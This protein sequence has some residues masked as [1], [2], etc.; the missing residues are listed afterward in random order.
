MGVA[1]QG[2]AVQEA[3]SSPQQGLELLDDEAVHSAAP[4]ELEMQQEEQQQ[5]L[6]AEK[7]QQEELEEQQRL[8]EEQ[9]R[10]LA[11]QEQEQLRVEQEE[12]EQQQRQI[13]EQRVKREAEEEGLQRQQRQLEAEERQQRLALEQ[14]EEEERLAALEQEQQAREEEEQ[15]A[16]QL[17]EEEAQAQ[18]SKEVSSPLSSVGGADDDDNPFGVSGMATAVHS[19][20]FAEEEDEQ[21][22]GV[23]EREG[24]PFA[25]KQQ[26]EG[27]G[28]G[29]MNM[30]YSNAMF[31]EQG[32]EGGAQ[33][34]VV[35]TEVTAV[36]PAQGYVGD[37]VMSFSSEDA[38]SEDAD[39]VQGVQQEETGKVQESKEE[40]VA[41]VE[42][43]MMGDL[44]ESDS[45]SSVEVGGKDEVVGVEAGE[46]AQ[47][48]AVDLSSEDEVEVF[49]QPNAAASSTGAEEQKGGQDTPEKAAVSHS[50]SVGGKAAAAA[51]GRAGWGDESFDVDVDSDE[52]EEGTQQ[53]PQQHQP[54]QSP[55]QQ[56]RPQ[57]LS[58]EEMEDDD[59]L[60]VDTHVGGT[61]TADAA[62][63]VGPFPPFRQKSAEPTLPAAAAAV[64]SSPRGITVSSPKSIAVSPK[65]IEAAASPQQ[66]STDA[67]EQTDVTRSVQGRGAI[68]MSVQCI[69]DVMI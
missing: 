51:P 46:K 9:E 21:S 25:G 26:H 13:E 60:E 67:P 17:H 63:A 1:L 31:D 61:Y 20:P 40:R 45:D 59:I 34:K 57:S 28:G 32:G 2:E 44:D 38:Y 29:I 33:E 19:N 55:Q 18:R 69:E 10:Q 47:L 3:L 53:S 14:Q 36:E 68:L 8:L 64:S 58:L 41:V 50:A 27:P 52:E 12:L 43:G 37:D 5:R 65:G 49:R 42:G 16:Q 24:N 30:A 23:D 35:T 22:A 4:H 56:P 66:Q 6:E 15:R 62:A 11:E 54:Q 7:Q 39:Q 48:E